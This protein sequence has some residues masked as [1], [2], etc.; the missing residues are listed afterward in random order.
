MEI[1]KNTVAAKGQFEEYDRVRPVYRGGE[2]KILF[3]GNSIT[4]HAPAA[5]IG[6]FDDWGMAASAEEKDYV[7]VAVGMLDGIFGKVDYCTACCGDWE[8]AYFEDEKI[9]RWKLAADFGADVIVVRLGENIWGP[10]RENLDAVPLYPHLDKFVKYFKTKKNAV[11]V[12]T[13]LFWSYEGIDRVIK[14]V[15]DDNGYKFVRIGDLGDKDEMKALGLFAH[16]GVSLH[17]NDR[18]MRF[19]A[20]RIV[21]EIK[22]SL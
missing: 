18:G 3:L 9:P 10:L 16:E 20:E 19:I 1:E 17:P 14:K 6:W 4:R 5:D 22:N 15:C 21:E 2:K 12:M 8:R 7:H 11:V 13:D